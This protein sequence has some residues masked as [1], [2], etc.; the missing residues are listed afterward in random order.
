M[1]ADN[2]EVALWRSRAERQAARADILQDLLY[3]VA[4]LLDSV[5]N[6]GHE[7]QELDD[8]LYCE[9][10]DEDCMGQGWPEQG[11]RSY[12]YTDEWGSHSIS[13]CPTCDRRRQEYI[14]QAD[15]QG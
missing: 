5:R 8:R 10:D 1:M 6:S 13:R 14:A 12:S 2:E 11:F 9:A 3:D 7:T 15:G 4:E